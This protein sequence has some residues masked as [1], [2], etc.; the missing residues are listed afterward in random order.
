VPAANRLPYLTGEN[1]AGL[2]DLTAFARTLLDDENAAAMFSTLGGSTNFNASAAWMKLPGGLIV[3]W[4]TSIQ[5]VTGGGGGMQIPLPTAYTT[6]ASYS[7]MAMNGQSGSGNIMI[8]EYRTGFPTASAFYVVLANAAGA[9][10][11]GTYRV[12]WITVGI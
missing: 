1:S 12:N 9:V 11:N 5:A 3:Q 4:G 7:K 8:Q 2:T 6:S 10:P